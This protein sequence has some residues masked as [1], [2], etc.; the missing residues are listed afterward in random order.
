M[1][2][3]A[4]AQEAPGRILVADDDPAMR[5]SLEGLLSEQ[6]LVTTVDSAA[7]AEATLDQAEFDVVLTDYEMPGGT[8]IELM[9]K[10]RARFPDVLV[11]CLTGHPEQP[12][13]RAA[14]SALALV[15][16]L[17]KPYD[18]KRLLT[19][20]ENAVR[21]ARVQRATRRLGLLGGNG[22]P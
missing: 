6:Y 16:V 9:K 15:R 22:G 21:L 20:V 4:H 14:E 3:E 2:S 18:P 13:L 7:R 5:T 11:I 17:G 8:G 10:V 1:S 19:W 12:D